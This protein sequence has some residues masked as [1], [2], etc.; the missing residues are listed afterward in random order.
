M[1]TQD[2][3]HEYYLE[4]LKEQNELE[5]NQDGQMAIAIQM[6]KEKL[7]VE[8]LNAQN[9]RAMDT[10]GR[11]KLLIVNICGRFHHT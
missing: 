4:R 7:H 11:K 3:I 6:D 8:I 5:K 2:L 10:N 1:E 9:I